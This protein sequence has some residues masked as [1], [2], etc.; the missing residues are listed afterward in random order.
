MEGGAAQLSWSGE[1][2]EGVGRWRLR[3]PG[4]PGVLKLGPSP[5]GVTGSAGEVPA[6][7]GLLNPGTTKP[8]S[9]Q[10]M[11]D[12]AKTVV[13]V[14]CHRSPSICGMPGS[15]EEVPFLPGLL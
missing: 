1:E 2:S 7:C 11:V 3:R 6:L 4:R 13:P 8:H 14:P 15:A 10:V 12:T 5:C 9:R